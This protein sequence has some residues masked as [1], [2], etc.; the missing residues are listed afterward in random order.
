MLRK[1]KQQ[2]QNTFLFWKNSFPFA[3]HTHINM[4]YLKVYDVH[5]F[6]SVCMYREV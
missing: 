5:G 2:S 1:K 4:F 3:T 6:S